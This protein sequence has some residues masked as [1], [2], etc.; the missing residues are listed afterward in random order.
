MHI[1]IPST[2]D[3]V[4]L[5]EGHGWPL[6]SIYLPT[7]VQPWDSQEN[8]LAA[9]GLVDEAIA[10]VRAEGTRDQSDA[11]EAHLRELLDDPVFWWDMARSLALF[12]TPQAVV[13]F[14]LPSTLQPSVTVADRFSITPLL[15]ALTFPHAAFVLALSQNGARL[16]EVAAELAAQE[17]AVAGLPAD[18]E[19]AVAG[20]GLRGRSPRGRLQGSEGQKVRLAQYARAVDHAVRPVVSGQPLPLLLAAT[21][22]LAGIFRGLTGCAGLADE[23]IEGSPDDMT[24][25][26]LADAARPVLDRLHAAELDRLRAV[27]DD[28]RAGGRATTDPSDLARAAAFGAIDTL[29]VD[30]DATTLGSV[31]DDG[32]LT[33]GS[34]EPLVDALARRVVLTGGRVLAIRAEDLPGGSE[35]A[36]ILR[37]AV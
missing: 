2:D 25:A 22:P 29:A 12:V 23:T 11:I 9:R 18:A 17:V 16:V 7:T 15:R 35:A 28:R 1:D 36:G 19:D 5:A 10:R 26:Q 37:Y 3:V 6:I 31:G 30:M 33:L 20:P 34:G 8:Q 13:E 4:R 27:F 14:R 21:E 24:P 32:S